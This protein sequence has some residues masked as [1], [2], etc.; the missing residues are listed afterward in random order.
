TG[1]YDIFI[2][3]LDANGNFIWA[4]NMGGSFGDNRGNS[5]AIDDSGNVY[6]TGHFQGT[7]DF[8]PGTSTYNLIGAGGYD[9][10]ISKLDANGNFVWAKRMGGSSTDKAESIIIDDFNNIYTIGKFV[11][12]ADFDPGTSTYNLICTGTSDIFISKLD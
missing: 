2:S 6:T 7:A 8:D 1:T 11:G 4:K 10:F 3:K 5:I 12:T 9:I